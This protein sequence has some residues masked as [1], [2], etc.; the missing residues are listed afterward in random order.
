MDMRTNRGI[1]SPSALALVVA[2]G[3]V[4]FAAWQ[5]ATAA[6]G[7][8]K[9][10][11]VDPMTVEAADL[12]FETFGR[13]H[14]PSDVIFPDQTIPLRF[15]HEVHLELLECK[16]CHSMANGSVRA[17]DVNLPPESTCLD[18]HDVKSWAEGK[19]SGPPSKCETCHPGYVPEWLP[20]ADK[21]DTHQV[22]VFP[23]KIVIP[24]PAIKFNHKIHVDKG[25]QCVTCHQGLDKVGIATRDNALP[26]MGTCVSCHDGKKAADDCKTCHL[27]EPNGKLDTTLP[28]G[29]LEPAGW[30]F[31]DA[32]DDDWMQ[33]HR[34][35]AVLGDGKCESCHSEKECVDCHNGVQK[36]L[37]IHPNNWVLQHASI[38]KKNEPECGS[39]HRSQ[40]FCVDCH[41][42]TKV[43][44]EAPNT[45]S[46]RIQFHPEGW[47]GDNNLRGPN[48]H[49]FQAQRNIRACA[50][51]HT[52]QT[53]V[54]CHSDRPGSRYF[55]SPHPPGWAGS[56]DCERMRD[57]NERVCYKCHETAS[58]EMRCG[59]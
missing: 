59:L 39:C 36:P 37:R 3:L 49:S 56:R 30:Y 35:V 50:S 6:P 53:C 22:K 52:E 14:T 48:H 7:P 43:V 58:Q 51:C 47:I 41:Q 5:A 9:K 12:P 31:M 40:T 1:A 38:A 16:D 34:H 13:K 29:K 20:G 21:S 25:V 28:H 27:T 24:E 11:S 44:V 18:C 42:A 15:S 10:V 4:V 46:G 23:P 8:E 2:A 26:V 19:N 55:A 32:H 54:S 57:K 33:N 45:I 17:K